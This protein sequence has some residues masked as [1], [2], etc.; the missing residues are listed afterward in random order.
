MSPKNN[1]PM[2][3]PA[4]HKLSIESNLEKTPVEIFQS[5]RKKSDKKILQRLVS[6][7]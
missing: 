3:S 1:I 4:S 6:P 7:I 5:P 2:N